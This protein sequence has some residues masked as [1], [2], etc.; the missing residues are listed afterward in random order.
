MSDRD[1]YTD[2]SPK[3]MSFGGA[4]KSLADSITGYILLPLA[5][6]SLLGGIGPALTAVIPAGSLDFGML[7]DGFTVYL[8]N[9]M[10]YS[11][12]L[13]FLSVFIGL[14]EPGSYARIPFK[15]ISSIYLAMV[16]LMFT[17]GGCMDVSIDG[18]GMGVGMGMITMSLEIQ[19]VIYILAV[20]SVIKGFLAFAEFSDN[21]KKYLKDM[22]KKFNKKEKKEAEWEYNEE[23]IPQS[24]KKKKDEDD[25]EEDDEDSSRKKKK[26]KRPV[27][28]DE[29]YEEY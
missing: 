23:D 18:S 28:E 26:K 27:E 24:K 25:D 2:F 14:Y 16:L 21:R 6:I 15:F 13:I 20:I 19:A 7:L 10:I 3:C 22:A 17:K 8:R 11:I 29:E 1:Y 5:A 12:P 4:F 9:L